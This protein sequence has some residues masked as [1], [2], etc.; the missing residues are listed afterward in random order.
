ML[1]SSVWELVNFTDKQTACADL[2]NTCKTN[3]FSGELSGKV[4]RLS[5]SRPE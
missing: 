4:V 3:I 1:I 5:Y 2:E